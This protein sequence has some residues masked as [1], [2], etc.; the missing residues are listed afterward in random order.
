MTRKK[1]RKNEFCAVILAAGK[2]TRMKSDFPKVLHEIDGKPLLQYVLAAAN[3]AGAEKVIVIIGHQAQKVSACFPESSCVFVLQEHQLGTGHAVLQ[4]KSELAHYDGLTVILCGDV[5]LLK[6]RTINKMIDEHLATDAT[7]TVLTA[8]VPDAF[9]YGR[10]I[11]DG[12][13]AIIKIAEQA[14]AKESE[15]IIN[16]IN[17]GIYCAQTPFLLEAL[18]KIE[19]NNSKKEYYLTDIVE[20]ARR[21]NFKVHACLTDNYLEVMGINTPEEL[22]RAAQYLKK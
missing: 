5:P 7:L 19:N 21:Q 11:K 9:G 3:D 10:I 6:P 20:I 14:D 2:G 4:A 13:G 12:Q 15:K 22:A 1:E 18:E 16:E 17:T 8:I